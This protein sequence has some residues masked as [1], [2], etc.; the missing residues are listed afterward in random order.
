MQLRVVTSSQASLRSQQQEL[1]IVPL[2]HLISKAVPS[3]RE[4]IPEPDREPMPQHES[5]YDSS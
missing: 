4:A 3:A 5:H 1:D 2:S